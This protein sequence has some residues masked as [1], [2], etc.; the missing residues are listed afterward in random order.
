M[1]VLTGQKRYED[2]DALRSRTGISSIHE[3]SPRGLVTFPKAPALGVVALEIKCPLEFWRRHRHPYHSSL[4]VEFVLFLD[5]S[6]TMGTL[7]CFCSGTCPIS[8]Q[9][10]AA[11][12]AAAFIMHFDVTAHLDFPTPGDNDG[13]SSEFGREELH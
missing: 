6:C 13:V 3:W 10:G 2:R 5:L 11:T 9:P 8:T 12:L 1:L 4:G 7:A